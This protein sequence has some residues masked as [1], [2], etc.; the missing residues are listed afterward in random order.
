[1]TPDTD[2]L[3]LWRRDHRYLGLNH[4]RNAGRTRVVMALSS[5]MMATEI[6]AGSLFGSLALLADGLHMAAHVM[7]LAAAAYAYG[8]ARR[9]ADADRFSFGTG[10]IGDL[11]GFASA[12]VLAIVALG[13]L[14]ESARRLIAPEPI[15]FREALIVAAIGFVVNLVSARLLWHRREYHAHGWGHGR[16]DRHAHDEG[17]GQHHVDH[18]LQAAYLHILT[19]VLT[20]VLAILA[21]LSVEFLGWR[22]MDPLAGMI[23]AIVILQWSWRLMRSTGNVL[24]DATSGAAHLVREAIETESGCRVADLHVWRIGPGHLAAMVTV[25][26]DMPMPPG[27]Y[28]ELLAGISG[29]SHVTVEVEQ[30]TDALSAS[31]LLRHRHIPAEPSV[32]K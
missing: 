9:H 4:D 10:K 20:S 31:S 21:L 15:V 19:D 14:Y 3:A 1:M 8:Y 30:W 26:A 22:W 13:M 27:H 29:L 5:I 11:V 32:G 25:V 12:L 18:N 16:A 7:V 23:G 24:L 17:H 6:A 28:K 2:S